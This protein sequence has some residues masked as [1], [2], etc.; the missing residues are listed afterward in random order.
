MTKKTIVIFTYARAELLRDCIRSVLSADGNGN[1]K[2]VLACHVGHP[3]VENVIKEFESEFDLVLRMK[4]QHKD[5]LANINLGSPLF[6]LKIRNS[7][8]GSIPVWGYT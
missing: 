3:D 4:L 8:D 7:G 1:W 5:N 2:K 6:I